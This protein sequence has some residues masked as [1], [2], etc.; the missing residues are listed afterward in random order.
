[1][2]TRR[3][4][5]VSLAIALSVAVL[6]L[7]GCAA[8]GEPNSAEDLLVRY[9]SNPDNTNCSAD[10]SLDL[11]LGVSSFRAGIPVAATVETADSFTKGSIDVDMTQIGGE[12]QKYDLYAEGH[13][14]ALTVYM[15][16]TDNNS[17]EWERTEASATFTVDIPMIV[18]LLSDAKFMRVAY[19]S[20]DQICYELTLPAKT[21]VHSVLA[22]GEIDTS[23]WEV[24]E[25]FL[26]NMLKDSKLHVC[27]NKDCLIRSVKL[28]LNFTYEDKSVIP[29]PVK[30]SLSLDA[31][32]DGYGSIEDAQVEVPSTVKS[33]SELTDDPFHIYDTADQLM[34]A[35][36]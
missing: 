34:E 5:F 11:N 24:D 25:E 14:N 23:F 6:G 8:L 12:P 18:N 15:N 3:T 17:K 30:V 10:V 4:W 9:A 20:D 29:V 16:R 35:S 2:R 31:V 26:D 1:M 36:S 28:D 13:D 27:F 32:M 7:V 21:L 22:M 33:Q 19:A